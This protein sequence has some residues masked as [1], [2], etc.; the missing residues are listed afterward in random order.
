VIPPYVPPTTSGLFDID[1]ARSV[2]RADTV[3]LRVPFRR[4]RFTAATL[5]VAFVAVAALTFWASY[6]VAM[7]LVG[8]G[9]VGR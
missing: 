3:P 1:G 4:R 2:S 9:Q 5:A 7:W 8:T 6:R